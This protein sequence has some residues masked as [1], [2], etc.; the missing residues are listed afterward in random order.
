MNKKMKFCSVFVLALVLMISVSNFIVCADAEH[1]YKGGA[2]SFGH[3]KH[4]HLD[5]NGTGFKLSDDGNVIAK[6]NQDK[7]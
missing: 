5:Y 4:S 1:E 7:S 3:E 2:W 6:F